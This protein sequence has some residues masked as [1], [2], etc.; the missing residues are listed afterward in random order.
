MEQL[1]K[2]VLLHVQA[3]QDLDLTPVLRVQPVTTSQILHV[4]PVIRVVLNVQVLKP[5]HVPHVL[6]EY[7][8]SEASV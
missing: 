7:T 6:T 3:V 5:E 8:Y 2:N 4:Y 1:A